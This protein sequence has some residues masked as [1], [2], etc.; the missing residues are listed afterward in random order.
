VTALVF[1][2]VTL[3]AWRFTVLVTAD[4]LTRPVRDWLVTRYPARMVPLRNPVDG[5]PLPDTAVA[6][7]HWFVAFV[8]CPWCVSVWASAA[9]WPIAVALGVAHSWSLVAFAVP[10]SAAACGALSDLTS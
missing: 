6:R 3:A 7:P 10:A 2:I 4:D 9:V 8:N 5:S 1:S